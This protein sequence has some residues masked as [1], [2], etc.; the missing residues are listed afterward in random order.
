MTKHEENHRSYEKAK[1]AYAALI[2]IYPLT[3][4]DLDGEQW[5][6]VGGYEGLYQVSNF[7][8]VKSFHR[9]TVKILKP[10][11]KHCYLFI[12]LNRAGNAEQILIHRLV[13]QEFIP[14]P[15]GKPQV[16]HR[17]GHKLNNYVDNLEWVTGS[18]NQQHAVLNGLIKSG[19]KNY[20]AKL[21]N[22]QAEY[23]RENPNKLSQ[24][25]LADKFGVR[26]ATISNVQIGKCYRSAGGTIRSAQKYTPRLS[27]EIREEIRQIYIKGDKAFGARSLA[28]QYGCSKTTIQRILNEK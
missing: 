17:D 16:N 14:N 6:D 21:T 3:L 1:P 8:R 24:K 28:R 13:A 10:A 5:H 11:L 20:N 9:G 4:D 27:N 12:E 2:K 23:I 7:G 22:G 26:L 15:D 19:E 25:E 18:E